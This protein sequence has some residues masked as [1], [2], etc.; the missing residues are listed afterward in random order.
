M[1]PRQ[2]KR[3]RTMETVGRL[4]GAVVLA[5]LGVGCVTRGAY[6]AKVNELNAALGREQQL[7]Y[8]IRGIE[9]N[10]EELERLS[11][12]QDEKKALGGF[13]SRWDC[14]KRCCRTFFGYTAC[15]PTCYT[16]CSSHNL[17]CN[18]SVCNAVCAADPAY[19]TLKSAWQA[20]LNKKVFTNNEECVALA[21]GGAAAA[22][23]LC[24]ALGGGIFCTI[25]GKFSE[26]ENKCICSEFNLPGRPPPQPQP[27]ADTGECNAARGCHCTC[28]PPRVCHAECVCGKCR[29][30]AD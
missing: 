20:A 17:L 7:T 4:G 18:P 30:M 1:E 9:A 23:Q 27:C 13:C 29:C 24:S 10:L 2:E 19:E 14:R 11:P 25:G 15:E 6:N 8:E 28:K 16:T 21:E 3:S 26:V 22:Q 5:I 12:G